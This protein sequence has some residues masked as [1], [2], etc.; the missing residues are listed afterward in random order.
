MENESGAILCTPTKTPVS[1][2]TV[3]L[4]GF[5]RGLSHKRALGARPWPLPGAEG[6]REGVGD[7]L[8]LWLRRDAEGESL[9]SHPATCGPRAGARL[10]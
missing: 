9:L 7:P 3:N 8:S 4:S 1:I 2:S 5:F 6:R 10:R